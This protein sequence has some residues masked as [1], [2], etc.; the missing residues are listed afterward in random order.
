V[1]VPGQ[2]AGGARSGFLIA[3]DLLLTNHHVLPDAQTA[4]LTV[5]E[6]NYQVDWD[7]TMEPVRRFTCDPSF[8]HNDQ[9]LDYAIVRVNGAP[10]TSSAS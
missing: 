2:H 5:A 1:R 10:A 7:G 3:T 9:E 4:G 8:F 6:F